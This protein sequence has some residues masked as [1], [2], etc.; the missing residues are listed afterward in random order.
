MT[1]SANY[2]GPQPPPDDR[3]A[4][5]LDAEP[6]E[7]DYTVG[8]PQPDPAMFHGLIGKVA[9]AA[10]DGTEVNPVAASAVFMTFLSASIGRKRYV[11]VGDKRHHPRIWT[12][13]L[14]RT[15]TA[16]K[17]MA[18]DLLDL[19]REG[20]RGGIDRHTPFPVASPKLPGKLSTGEGTPEL[21]RGVKR[22]R[23]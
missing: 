12:L 9:R 5:A 15:S 4:P 11:M 22:G 18:H 17:G 6:A 21:G 20:L 3:K 14:G 10:A 13:H 16:G 7:E 1:R 2:C 19:I 8:L 23:A